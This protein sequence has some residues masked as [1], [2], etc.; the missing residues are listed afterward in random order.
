MPSDFGRYLDHTLLR[1]TATAADVRRL[2]GEAIHHA[3]AAVCIFPSFVSLAREELRHSRVRIAAVIA[4]PFGATLTEVKEY[5]LRLAA[6]RG[7]DEADFVI[8]IAAL[9][10]GDEAA[11]EAEMQRLTDAARALG[12]RSKF[13]IETAY[14]SHQEKIRACTMANRVRPDFLKTSTGY[15]PAGAT[16]EDI[17]LMRENLLPEIQIKAAGGIRTHRQALGL[18]QAGA[19]RLGT[20][21]GVQI[22]KEAEQ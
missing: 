20:S 15:A 4:F 22:L 7:A 11:V 17:R 21:S 12:V 2:C 3:M 13:I 9:K 16:I 10:S 5:E 1:P 19:S 8:N 14:L 6:A 18:L